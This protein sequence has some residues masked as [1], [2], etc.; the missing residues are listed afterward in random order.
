M[1]VR[2]CLTCRHN[3]VVAGFCC[4]GRTYVSVAAATLSGVAWSVAGTIFVIDLCLNFHVGFIVTNNFQRRIVMDAREVVSYYVRRGATDAH[5]GRSHA[6]AAPHCPCPCPAAS[7]CIT[8]WQQC[9]RRVWL[10]KRAKY[11][12]HLQGPFDMIFFQQLRGALRWLFEPF[13]PVH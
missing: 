4:I 9:W 8:R 6:H 10:T 1:F 11:L 12:C 13:S 7:S 2:R 3:C 5:C